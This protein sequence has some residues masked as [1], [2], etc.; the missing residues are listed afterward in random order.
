MK[1]FISFLIL[2]I[3]FCLS[4]NVF[5]EDVT[6]LT[7]SVSMV[8]QSFYGMWRVLSKLDDTDNPQVFKKSGIDLWNL[9]KTNDVI[10]L[11]NPFNGA[12]AEIKI[13][14]VDN[15]FIVFKKIGKSG[16]KQFTDI[17]EMQLDGENFIGID[18]IKLDTFVNGKIM[19]SEM[20]VYSIK[21]E[22]ISGEIK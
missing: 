10:I 16:N 9:S 1:K 2:I 13:D 20:A 11:C 4:S 21:G 3:Y 7:G 12:N 17:V 5:A 22:K 18:K 14:K 19:K 8:P 6:T 15:N